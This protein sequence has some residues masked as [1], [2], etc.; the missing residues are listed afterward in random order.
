[1]IIFKYATNPAIH[2][3][4]KSEPRNVKWFSVDKC[5]QER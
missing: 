2:F 1:L 5:E 4:V 3:N